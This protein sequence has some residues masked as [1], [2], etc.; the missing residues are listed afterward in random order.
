M[1]LKVLEK[2]EAKPKFRKMLGNNKVQGK[3]KWR[4]K[5]Q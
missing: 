4:I 3:K 5:E 2:Q 1:L